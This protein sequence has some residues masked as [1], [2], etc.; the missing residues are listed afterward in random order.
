MKMMTQSKPCNKNIR[1]A[2]EMAEQLMELADEGDEHRED[3]GCG[4]LFGVIRDSAYKIKGQAE[5]EMRKH[6]LDGKWD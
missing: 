1:K 3:D 4:V 2:L 6:Q 5:K